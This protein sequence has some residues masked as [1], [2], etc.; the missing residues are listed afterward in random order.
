MPSGH[1][2]GQLGERDDAIGAALASGFDRW[3][4]DIRAG[5][6]VMVSSDELRPDA[7][8]AWPASSTLASVQGGLVLSQAP[9]DPLAL[10]WSL[11]GALALIGSFRSGYLRARASLG[12]GTP[13]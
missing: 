10:R 4:V 6:V 1:S 13:V 5:L 8:A 9:R 7:D 12:R 11:D 2:P 3:E